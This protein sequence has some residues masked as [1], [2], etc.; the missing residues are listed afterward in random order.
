MIF[1]RVIG[2]VTW[3]KWLLCEDL[4]EAR[5]ASVQTKENREYR[6]RKKP[7]KSHRQAW[8]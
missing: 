6:H 2:K 5:E 4:N 3:R 8:T 7:Y 1:N